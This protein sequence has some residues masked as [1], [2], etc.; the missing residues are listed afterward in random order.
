MPTLDLPLRHVQLGQR[1]EG[2]LSYAGRF[3]RRLYV[4]HRRL[5]GA[6]TAQRQAGH[7]QLISLAVFAQFTFQGHFAFRRGH[8]HQDGQ[9]GHVNRNVCVHEKCSLG[10]FQPRQWTGRDLTEAIPYGVAVGR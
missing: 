8:A 3:R 7:P 2:S 1:D 6:V 4:D 5:A 9:S 10:I